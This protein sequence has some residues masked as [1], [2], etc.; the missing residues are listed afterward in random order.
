MTLWE[1][2]YSF[3]LAVFVLLSADTDNLNLL[4]VRYFALQE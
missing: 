4:F 3:G 1:I 2:N